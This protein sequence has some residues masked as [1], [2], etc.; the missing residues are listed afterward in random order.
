M[1]G[2]RK[3]SLQSV[4]FLWGNSTRHWGAKLHHYALFRPRKLEIFYTHW[5]S[6]KRENRARNPH[7]FMNIRH[8]S[9]TQVI[10]PSSG[11]KRDWTWVTYLM[12][13]CFKNTTLLCS[14]RWS[15]ALIT[16]AGQQWGHFYCLN[17]NMHTWVNIW[18]YW[19]NVPNHP[20]QRGLAEGNPDLWK[21]TSTLSV[22]FLKK[23]LK[24]AIP[25]CADPNSFRRRLE[26]LCK[27]LMNR[28][29]Q[30]R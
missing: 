20:I 8:S 4:P 7:I 25:F 14:S 29:V 26:V 13:E 22:L 6:F 30:K 9:G 23:S 2:H 11:R 28:H 24:I 12:T 19:A 15:T 27:W 1:I 10:Y 3:I 17:R 16:G 18:K 5:H 21:H